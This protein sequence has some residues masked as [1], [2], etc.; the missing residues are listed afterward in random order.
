MTKMRPEAIAMANV[1]LRHHKSIYEPIAKQVDINSCVMAYG[2]MCD[3]AGVPW[4]M[5]N[6]GGFLEEIASWCSD[7]GW[8]PLN[9]LAVNGESRMPG[10]G[11]DGA[12]GCSL[13][14]WASEAEAC[15]KF[16]GYPEKV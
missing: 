9:S 15:I 10:D 7:N 8:P 4:L 6:P 13:I 14:N 11:Y 1:L 3:L 2:K 5:R 16:S 12:R